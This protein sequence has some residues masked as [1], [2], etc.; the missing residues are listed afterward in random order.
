MGAASGRNFDKDSN[1]LGKYTIGTFIGEEWIYFKRYVDRQESCIAREPSCVLQIDVDTYE[2]IRSNLL[3]AKLSK[4]VSMLESQLKRSYNN[5]K[6]R[7]FE[8]GGF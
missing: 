5:K 4:D 8:N 6:A 2:T 1:S 3:N 7:M